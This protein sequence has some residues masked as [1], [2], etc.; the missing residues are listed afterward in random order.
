MEDRYQIIAPISEECIDAFF[1]VYDGH[2]SD[3][4]STYLENNLHSKILSKYKFEIDIENAIKESFHQID[5]EI[6]SNADIKG[7]STAIIVY[8][9]G[10]N[11]F[12]V[13]NCGDS[14]VGLISQNKLKILNDVHLVSNHNEKKMLEDK[15]A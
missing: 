14:K 6:M 4:I 12:Y 10:K 7:G 3:Q 1:A 8:I 5:K 9:K 2:N 15:G 11:K 13:A